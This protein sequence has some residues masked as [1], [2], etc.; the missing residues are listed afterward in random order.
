MMIADCHTSMKQQ[1]QYFSKMDDKLSKE[2]AE[3]VSRALK[4]KSN[5]QHV[6]RK[7]DVRNHCRA[8]ILYLVGDEAPDHIMDDFLVRHK[9]STSKSK[10]IQHIPY[11]L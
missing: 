9:M 10:K 7:L 5:I 3:L 1:K 2:H 6:Q 11:L 8:Q 4:E